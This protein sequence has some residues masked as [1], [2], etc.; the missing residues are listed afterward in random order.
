M[1]HIALKYA[2]NA[3]HTQESFSLSQYT[4]KEDD[5]KAKLFVL[6]FAC[7]CFYPN[8]QIQSS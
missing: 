5:S 8:T 1:M 2:N 7:K 3:Y 6:L 4:N